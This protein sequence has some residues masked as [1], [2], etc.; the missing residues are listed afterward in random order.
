MRNFKGRWILDRTK[1]MTEPEVKELRRVVE[2]KARSGSCDRPHHL[3]PVLD[4]P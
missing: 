3:A 1:Y 2:N 4:G